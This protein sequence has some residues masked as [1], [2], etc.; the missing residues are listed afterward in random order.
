MALCLLMSGR[1]TLVRG[2]GTANGRCRNRCGHQT[3]PTGPVV[4][5]SD[6]PLL[7]QLGASRRRQLDTASQRMSGN[8]SATTSFVDGLR[9]ER[10]G[11]R[12]LTCRAPREP[13]PRGGLRRSWRS[14]QA[15]RVLLRPGV[16][17]HVSRGRA[18][19]SPVPG[20]ALG[21]RVGRGPAPRRSVERRRASRGRRPARPRA[22]HP[23]RP[24][25]TARPRARAARCAPPPSPPT[26]ARPRSSSSPRAG[27]RSAAASTS[28]IPEVLAEAAAAADLGLEGCLA[29]A[30]DERVATAPIEEAGRTLLAAGADRAARRCASAGTCTRASSASRRRPPPSAGAAPRRAARRHPAAARP[31]A[32]RLEGHNGACCRP[33]AAGGYARLGRAVPARRS[34]RH[35]SSWRS[36]SSVGGLL[37]LHLYVEHLHGT[38]SGGS[39]LV[40]AAACVVARERVRA[41]LTFGLLRPVD[42]WLR[43]ERTPD[44]DG[45]RLA[46]AR[47]PA[48]ATSCALRS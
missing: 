12:H 31:G 10:H 41:A 4:A 44:G 38:T 15:G 37:L 48:A 5:T 27:S 46:R 20:R 42:P 14:A 35:S 13:P 21:P 7:C 11:R 22:A 1:P 18:H 47:R 43:G 9:W 32:R 39:L 2:P 17:V 33:A 36:S 30:R 25:P 26:A 40:V 34:S 24:G 3:I 23:A 29:A 45:R 8:A 19:R 16:A 6:G 28:T